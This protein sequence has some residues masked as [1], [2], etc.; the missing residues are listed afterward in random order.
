MSNLLALRSICDQRKQ[1]QLYNIPL[2][3]YTPISPYPQFTEFQLNMRRKAEILKYSSNLSSSQTN[4]L[5]KNQK[6]SKIVGGKY[7][8]NSVFCPNDLSLP[9]LSSSCDVPG[10]ITVLYNDSNV[11]LYNFATN[12]VAY[13]VDN[14]TNYKNFYTT[15]YDN[16]FIPNE[17]ETTIATLYIQNNKNV[18]SHP[19]T[20]QTPITFFISGSNIQRGEP[21]DLQFLLSSVSVLTYYSGQETLV[22]GNPPNYYYT[23]I[24]N[25]INLKLIPPNN[26]TNRFSYSTFVYEGILNITNLNL[27]TQPGYIYDIKLSFNTNLFS[28]NSTN[29]SILNNTNVSMYANITSDLYEKIVLPGGRPFNNINPYNCSIVNGASTDS[30]LSA[31]IKSDF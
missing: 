15:I 19:F 27:N 4:N 30:Y 8:G 17:S 31:S 11:P 24:K 9:T 7:R 6:F 13:A 14:T 21:Y 2:P 22:F 20:I 1:Q 5:T 23:N 29:S 26:T 10:P 18:A 25:P 12:N 3:R 16:V 28:S